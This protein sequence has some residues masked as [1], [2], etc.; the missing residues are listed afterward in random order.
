MTATIVNEITRYCACSLSAVDIFSDTISCDNNDHVIYRAG[1][2]ASMLDAEETHTIL[3]EWL[4]QT[5]TLALDGSLLQVDHNCP[6]VLSSFDDPICSSTTVVSPDVDSSSD[7]S[8]IPLLAGI[9]GG[10]IIGG[11]LTTI[12]V[13]ILVIMCRGKTD[14]IRYALSVNVFKCKYM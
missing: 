14:K 9:I 8:I 1:L 10:I 2:A 4:T 11:V 5:S 12:L 6:L 3:N 7:G 13:V